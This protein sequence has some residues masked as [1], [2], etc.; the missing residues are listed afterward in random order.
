MICACLR[1]LSGRIMPQRNRTTRGLP[2]A[3]ERTTAMGLRCRPHDERIRTACP[4]QS[5]GSDLLEEEIGGVHVAVGKRGLGELLQSAADWVEKDQA[6]GPPPGAH[7]A[8]IA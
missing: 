5:F 1:R 6:Y 7:L 8:K 3:Q 2:R 4:V